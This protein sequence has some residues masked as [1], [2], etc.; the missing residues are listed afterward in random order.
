[1]TC[2]ND[3]DPC[4]PQ[5]LQSLDRLAFVLE[6]PGCINGIRLDII[7]HLSGHLEIFEPVGTV[8]V[9]LWSGEADATERDCNTHSGHNG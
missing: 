8:I 5:T 3:G 2:D 1:M 7:L 9:V 4:H 6:G